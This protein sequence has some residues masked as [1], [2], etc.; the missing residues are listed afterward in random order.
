MSGTCLWAAACEIR[1]Q[2]Y[3]D[4]VCGQD[5]REAM[6]RTHRRAKVGK[7]KAA[8]TNNTLTLSARHVDSLSIPSVGWTSEQTCVKAK[9]SCGSDNR[10]DVERCPEG[11]CLRRAKG[12]SGH[13]S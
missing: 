10:R 6:T 9:V 7:G 8:G 3:Q 2:P 11:S 5:E 13:Q 4:N 12:L 1:G